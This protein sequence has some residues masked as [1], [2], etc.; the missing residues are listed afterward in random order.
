MTPIHELFNRIR[1]DPEF[2]AA[3]FTVGYYDR[4]AQRII[5]VRFRELL[6]DANDHFAFRVVDEEGALHSVPYH[7]VRE[8]FRNGELIWQRAGPQQTSD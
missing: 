1:W 3:A 2:G 8:M 7:R 6:F 5:R 4:V